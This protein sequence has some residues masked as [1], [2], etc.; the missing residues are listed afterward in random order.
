MACAK[1]N[2]LLASAVSGP[3]AATA[4]LQKL[5]ATLLSLLKAAVDEGLV[6]GLLCLVLLSTAALALQLDR[7][8]ETLDLGC[9]GVLHTVLC[10]DLATH[11]E[12]AHIII[13]GEVEELAD[14]RHTL[15]PQ[16][17]WLLLIR[18]PRNLLLAPLHNDEVEH[19]E[20]VAHNA[21]THR[22]ALHLTSAALTVALASL[23][24]QQAHA[25]GAQ[26]TLHHGEALLVVPA[27]DAEAVALELVAKG[28]AIDFL[29]HALVEEWQELLVLINRNALLQTRLGAAHVEL[30][31][32]RI[33]GFPM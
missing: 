3:V 16:A 9:L 20:V 31:G 33:W 24:E 1:L 14:L 29:G 32:E 28:V 5:L 19:R 26:D 22:L 12:L 4:L 30:L 27:S 13:L 18:Q 23:L 25:V 11:H 17:D 10:G 2:H 7:G 15:W 21:P 8:D 6:G